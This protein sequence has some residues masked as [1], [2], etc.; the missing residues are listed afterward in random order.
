VSPHGLAVVGKKRTFRGLPEEQGVPI[1]PE[2][3]DMP[4]VVRIPT[5]L[6]KFTQNQSEVQV[7]GATIDG[8]VV[9]LDARFPGIRERLCDDSGA[10]RKFINL[11][12]ND[13]DIRFMDGE[14][15]VV[16]DGDE[17]A[18]IPAIAG[19]RR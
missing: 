13:E 16:Q 3:V 15:T 7:S 1:V 17:V 10:I 18:I 11:Y 19:G 2:G 12:L 14:K 6:Q 9:E 5:P 4:V 8:V